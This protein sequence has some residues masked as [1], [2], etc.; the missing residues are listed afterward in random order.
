MKKRKKS[1]FF[2]EI[3]SPLV[4]LLRSL[5]SSLFSFHFPHRVVHE[6]VVLEADLLAG[7]LPDRA[8]V[9]ACC[10]DFFLKVEFLN[11]EVSF[12][13]VFISLFSPFSLSSPS[14]SSLLPTSVVP[15][16]VLGHVPGALGLPQ[17]PAGLLR[18]VTRP[19]VLEKGRAA[20]VLDKEPPPVLG[21]VEQDRAVVDLQDRSVDGRDAAPFTARR[22]VQEGRAID[23]KRRILDV[24]RAALPA[25]VVG[26]HRVEHAD[27]RRVV[28]IQRPGRGVVAG[29]E[30]GVDDGGPGVGEGDGGLALLT[31]VFFFF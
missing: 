14:P 9:A 8:G 2:F 27:D 25:A 5:S 3:S 22:V 11:D 19:R 21:G 15:E 23:D 16:A 18:Q 28:G 13:F 6:D 17:R 24:D 29:D 4:S 1:E 12:F 10:F 31:R 20:A 7:V 26:E 30:G